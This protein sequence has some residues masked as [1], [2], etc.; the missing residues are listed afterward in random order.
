HY[1]GTQ[2]EVSEGVRRRANVQRV[3]RPHQDHTPM[4]AVRNHGRIVSRSPV[5]LTAVGSRWRRDER[6]ADWVCFG[7][8]PPKAS[9]KRVQL[10]LFP[11][12]F[13]IKP[14]IL[15]HFLALFTPRIAP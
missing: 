8:E 9:R 3:A 5:G 4:K 15:N 1:H 12:H 10:A 14:L 13:G 7:A 6:R 2:A 11:G